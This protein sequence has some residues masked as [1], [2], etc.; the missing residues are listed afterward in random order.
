MKRKIIY[1]CESRGDGDLPY[2]TRW[3]LISG[4]MGA[5]Y[6]HWFHR[7][8]GDDRHDHPWGFWSIILWRGY[9]EE[10]A[11]D[12]EGSYGTMRQITRHRWWPG[13]VRYCCPE[14]T[15]RV[16]LIDGKGALSLVVRGPY[17]REWGFHTKSGWEHWKSYFERLG[18]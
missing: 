5:V 10:V 18:C 3:T 2:L 13:S 4:K 9:V 12:V 7:S 14:H 11:R 16:E 6:L 1:G 17:V 15:H 8:D